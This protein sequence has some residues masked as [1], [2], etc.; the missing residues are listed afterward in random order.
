MNRLI[1]LILLSLVASAHAADPKITETAD[2]VTVEYTGTPSNGASSAEKQ[3]AD[4]NISSLTRKET[5]KTQIKQL[6]QDLREISSR[7]ENA[8]EDELVKKDALLAEKNQQIEVY[9]NEINAIDEQ[10]Q[11]KVI[12]KIQPKEESEIKQQNLRQEMKKNITEGQ[13][14]RRQMMELGP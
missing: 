3:P 13:K 7:Y 5:L 10:A 4:S 12:D 14:L 11:Q 9:Q 6:Q 1:I 2:G 8:T